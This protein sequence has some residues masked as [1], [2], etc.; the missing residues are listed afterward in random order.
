MGRRAKNKQGDPAPLD[1]SA[2]LRK[3]ASSKRKAEGESPERVAKKSKKAQDSERVQTK[4]PAKKGKEAK[5]KPSHKEKKKPRADDDDDE[6]EGLDAEANEDLDT[7][8][9]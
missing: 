9:Q 4:P 6:W 2:L 7:Q 1:E 8:R 3:L 5:G